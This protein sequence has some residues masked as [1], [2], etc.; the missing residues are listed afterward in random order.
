VPGRTEA[1][2]ARLNLLNPAASFFWPKHMMF[3]IRNAHTDG[4]ES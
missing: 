2:V 4:A 1:F 3:I